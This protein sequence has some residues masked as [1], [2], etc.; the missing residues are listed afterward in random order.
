MTSP[1][2]TEIKGENYNVRYD[3]GTE[4]IVFQGNLQLID[5]DDYAAI[6]ALLDRVVDQEPP[7]L[8]LDLR[9]LE[10][11]NSS[12]MNMLLRHVLRIREKR[13]VQLVIQASSKIPWHSKSLTNLQRLM[14]ATQFNLE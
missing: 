4:T 7:V 3:P 10:F 11:L 9:K 5:M 13:T 14:P 8:T 12:G 2:D 6:M 1:V